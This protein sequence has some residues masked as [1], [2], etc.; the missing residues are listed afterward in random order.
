MSLLTYKEVRPWAK[1]IREEVLQR[2]MPP[3]HA[4]P[5]YGV[6]ENDRHLE[7]QEIDKIVAWVDSGAKEG[8]PKYMPP[9]PKFPDEGWSIGKPD[10]ILPMTEEASVPAEGVVAYRF[11]VV[12]TNFTE[13]KYVQAAEIRKGDPSV[14]HHV[15][16]NVREPGQGP[17][18]PAGELKLGGGFGEGG[19]GAARQ[20][21]TS[22]GSGNA[23]RGGNNPDGMLIGWAPGMMPLTLKPGQAK[24][25]KKGSVLIFQM[26]YTTSGVPAKDR[27]S[28][29]LIFSKAPVEKRVITTAA[30]ARGIDI[31]PGDPNYESH[32]VFTFKEDGHILSFMP[33]MHLRG[34]DFQYRLV[35]P[36]GTSKVVLDVPRYDF[37]WQTTYILKEP[38][39]APKGSR[40]ECTAHHDNSVNNKFNA[41]PSKEVRW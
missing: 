30:F 40:V 15:I 37:N 23:N 14:V 10:V 41:D 6:F 18:P 27:T 20:D 1:A 22:A 17:L 26:H 24:L 36:D 3:W 7:K 38:I 35:Y 8:D 9:V 11:Y 4:D 33:H 2:R 32:A 25:I 31:P 12:P 29:G 5:R 16:I 21:E 34:K 19:G 39:A 13:D 28:V